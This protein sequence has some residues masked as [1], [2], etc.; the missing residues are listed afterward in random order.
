MK[1]KKGDKVI[2]ISGKDKGK[3]GKIARAIPTESKV[4]IEG[5]NILKKHRKARRSG[6]KGQIVEVSM[7][8]HV[9]NVAIV[10]DGKPTRIGSK[11]IGGKK[12]RVDSKTG[13]AI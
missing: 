3:T 6:E 13:K 2:V 1:I 9:S 10:V 7:P 4:V 5:I 8:M 12:V 11:M